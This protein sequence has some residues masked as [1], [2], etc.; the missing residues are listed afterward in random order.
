MFLSLMTPDKLN[1]LAELTAFHW[2]AQARKWQSMDS[3]TLLHEAYIPLC[4]A[5]CEWSGLRLKDNTIRRRAAEFEAMIEGTG[6]VG[7]RNWRGHLMRARTERWMRKVIAGI[8]NGKLRVPKGSAAHVISTFRDRNGQL[9]DTKSAAVELINVLRPTVANARYIVFAAMALHDH[10]EW[11]DKVRASE[12][13]LDA[14]VDEV[15]RFYPFIPFVGGRVLKEFTW[16]DHRFKKQ[17][18]LLFDLYGTNHD[19]RIWGDPESFSPDRFLSQRFGRYELVSHGAGDRRLTHR[20]PGE[21][22]TVLQ[23]KAVLQLIASEMR[24]DV[25]LQDLRID[26]ARIPARPNSGFV[27]KNVRLEPQVFR[28]TAQAS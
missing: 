13:N 19:P 11:R 14:F 24:Y 1:H 6:S 18:W 15:R 8:R 25:P 9:M 7:P 10:P 21:W 12:K 4:A 27:V 28:E 23:M 16:R 22:I 5:I 26:L 17:D 2:W 3:I 20:C